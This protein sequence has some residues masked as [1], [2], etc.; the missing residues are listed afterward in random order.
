MRCGA[1]TV[2]AVGAMLLVPANA[3]FSQNADTVC[4]EVIPARPNIEPPAPI[5]ID[6]CSGRSWVLLRNGKSYRWSII[7]LEA[8]KPKTADRVQNEG[9]AA[10]GGASPKCFSYN[11]RKFCE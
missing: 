5:M 10:P 1:G 11:N 9:D 4:F 2:I 8:E 3:A 6:K 7:S